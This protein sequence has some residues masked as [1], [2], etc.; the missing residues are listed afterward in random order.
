MWGLKMNI[1]SPMDHFN[2]MRHERSGFNNRRIVT[3]P[4]LGLDAARKRV[5][6]RWSLDGRSDRASNVE[7]ALESRSIVEAYSPAVDVSHSSIIFP[8]RGATTGPRPG[9]PCRVIGAAEPEQRNGVPRRGVTGHRPGA[10]GVE[11]A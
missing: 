9:P 7:E 5:E 4:R 6:A 2:E 3:E 1:F 8:H 11:V 10:K